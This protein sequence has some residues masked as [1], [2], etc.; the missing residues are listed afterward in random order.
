LGVWL[1]TIATETIIVALCA[2]NKSTQAKDMRTAKSLAEE[3][4]E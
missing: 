2:G 3:W 4:S 1:A